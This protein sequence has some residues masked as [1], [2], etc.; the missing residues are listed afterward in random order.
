MN[1]LAYFT[2][3]SILKKKFYNIDIRSSPQRS[4]CNVSK[5]LSGELNSE[6]RRGR[7]SNNEDSDKSSAR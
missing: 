4:P 7:K 5:N 2:M 1:I 3:E 6:L